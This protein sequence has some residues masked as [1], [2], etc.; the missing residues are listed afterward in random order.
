MNRDILIC[1]LGE[2][3]DRLSNL[4]LGLAGFENL[5]L[6]ATEYEAVSD[7]E[8][9]QTAAYKAVRHLEGLL[10]DLVLD[11]VAAPVREVA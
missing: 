8:A 5:H 1:H 9:L 3:K 10:T 6:V 7:I 4:H 11:H 2:L